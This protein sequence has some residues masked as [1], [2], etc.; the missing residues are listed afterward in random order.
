MKM[1][2]I[3]HTGI[4]AR[5]PRALVDFYIDRLGMAL[6]RQ[7]GETTYFIGCEGGGILEVYQAKEGEPDTRTNYAQGLRHIAFVVEDFEAS[8]AALVAMGLEQP[9]PPTL[10]PPILKLALFRDPE[11]NLFHITQRDVPLEVGS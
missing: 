5:D 9:A 4:A 8:L 1:T 11:G 7:T 3:E 6:L 10:N 2:R